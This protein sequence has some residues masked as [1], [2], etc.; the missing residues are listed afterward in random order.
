MKSQA[1]D[2]ERADR[3]GRGQREQRPA[4]QVDRQHR[5]RM[6]RL[7]ANEN[8]AKQYGG[9]NFDQYDSGLRVMSRAA[10]PQNEKAETACG[11]Q[12]AGKIEGMRRSWRA[13]QCLQADQDR[14]K[15]EG[16]VDGKQPAPRPDR[17]N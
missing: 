12:R 9:G 10:D 14:N 13:R 17:E 1:L 15:A 7:S 11:Q 6:I 2:R 16:N 8:P 3:G 4:K 5:R